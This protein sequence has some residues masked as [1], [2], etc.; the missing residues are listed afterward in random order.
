MQLLSLVLAV[1]LAAVGLTAYTPRSKELVLAEGQAAAS[2]LAGQQ[3][4]FR[5]YSPSYSLPQ[6]TAARYGLEMA[7]G[8]DPLHLTAYAAYIDLASG[9]P[10]RGYGVTLP[11][12]DEG[13]PAGANRDFLPDP[14]SLG[15]LNVRWVA[16][17]YDLPVNGLVERERFGETRIYENLAALPRAWL[18]PVDAALGEGARPVKIE[19]T[20][21][22]ALR[23]N[24]EGVGLGE[25]LVLSEVSYP[26]WKVRLDGQPAGLKLVGGLLRGVLVGPGIKTVEF[27]FRPASLYAGLI[28]WLAGLCL[29]W[30]A[31]KRRL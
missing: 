20:S 2:F 17:E 9:V 4:E 30:V 15:L 12:F 7:S 23:L 8:V 10:R 18:Q 11:P 3:G 14:A 31:W 16:A 19:S 27:N 28:L 13:L 24:L 1:D 26:G 22:D 6:Q 21:P 5:V 25:M 29:G